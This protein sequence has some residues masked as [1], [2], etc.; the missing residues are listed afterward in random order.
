[1]IDRD[2]VA[3]IVFDIVCIIGLIAI[4]VFA[5]KCSNNNVVS[6]WNNGYCECGGHWVYEQAVG[7]AYRT[8]YI[9]RCDE[10][11]KTLEVWNTNVTEVNNN[12]ID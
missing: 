7:H 10:C 11:G 4:I 2:T 8:S 12:E 9:Y 5:V 3:T 1:M 6:A